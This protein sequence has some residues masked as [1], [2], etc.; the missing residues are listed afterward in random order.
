M[1]FWDPSIETPAARDYGNET[2][3]TLQAQID[4]APAQWESDAEFQPKYS[5]LGMQN[6]QNQL[7]GSNG[8]QLPGWDNPGTQPSVDPGQI[9]ST[10]TR[11]DGG[12]PRVSP[13]TSGDTQQQTTPQL[14]SE[15]GSTIP[16]TDSIY[17]TGGDGRNDSTPDI[18]GRLN[19]WNI[20]NGTVVTHGTLAKNDPDTPQ[21]TWTGSNWEESIGGEL[22]G[23][24]LE[25]LPDGYDPG[26]NFPGTPGSTPSSD[27]IT[28]DQ[29]GLLEMFENYVTPAMTR[30]ETE[31]N[32]ARRTADVADVNALGPEFREAFEAA[33]PD[34]AALM[35]RMNELTMDGL[36]QGL[37]A[38]ESRDSVNSSR[39]AQSARGFG[40]GPSDAVN[41]A[42]KLTVDNENR[43][44]TN[45]QKG[46]Q[47]S[48][49]NNA[50]SVDPMLALTG[51]SSQGG[52]AAMAAAGGQFGGALPQSMFNPESGYAS[53]VYNTNFN[54]E[55]SANIANGNNTAGIH[56]AVLG[57]L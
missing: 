40:L 48:A 31:S 1:S 13:T 7:L 5:L 45:Y 44:N 8:T 36:G 30:M 54:A 57:A 35:T 27:G 2:R 55:A 24:N 28:G 10:R 32:T 25:N 6:L 47:M 52:T 29:M 38:Q 46:M 37:T 43:R 18:P 9:E 14:S 19:D 49:A 53:D 23:N 39:G 26:G 22:T 41:E 15:D 3:D 50:F 4:L 16:S 21:Y 51:R 33:N 12:D 42:V 56:G 20:P 17:I 11:E 34:Q